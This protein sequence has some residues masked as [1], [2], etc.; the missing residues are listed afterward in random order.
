M[1][2][3]VLFL[4]VVCVVVCSAV[5][6]RATGAEGFAAPSG[7]K[8]SVGGQGPVGP[9]GQPAI[10]VDGYKDFKFGMTLKDL[11]SRSLC[12]KI[13]KQSFKLP[14]PEDA[15]YLCSGIP[16]NGATTDAELT[17][18]K[19]KLARIGIFIGSSS[20]DLVATQATLVDKYGQWN[21]DGAERSQAFVDGTLQRI[22]RHFVGGAISLSATRPIPGESSFIIVRV[23]YFDLRA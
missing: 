18:I 9:Q 17:F 13:E 10:T 20:R 19:G 7:P 21:G 12:R 11:S 6:T 5:S 16:F 22:E 23:D 14:P 3:R 2:P 1:H 4:V 15:G 8:G